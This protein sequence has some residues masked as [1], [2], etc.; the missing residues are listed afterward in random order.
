MIRMTLAEI[1]DAVGG[2]LQLAGADTP[3]TVVAGAV[4]TDSRAIGD[5]DIFVA[6]PGE[7]TDGTC[8]SPLRRMP[9]PRSRSSNT[10]S[11]CR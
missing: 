10:P 7:A 8:S 11:R 4:D 2:T 9:V 6:K 5:G 1:A 3:E